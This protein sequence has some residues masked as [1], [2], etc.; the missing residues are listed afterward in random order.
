MQKE[1]DQAGQVH[2]TTLFADTPSAR[3]S[4]NDTGRI[5][6]RRKIGKAGQTYQTTISADTT[7]ESQEPDDTGRLTSLP[8]N[9]KDM[10]FGMLLESPHPIKLNT[11]SL[12]GFVYSR[13]YVPFATSSQIDG[14][15]RSHC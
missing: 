2:Q 15:A 8:N 7:S 9:V 6:K 14:G 11:A 13:V 5:G 4:R 3:E 1:E 10:I 12:M